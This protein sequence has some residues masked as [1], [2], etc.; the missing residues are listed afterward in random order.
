MIIKSMNKTKTIAA[1][2]TPVLL[3]IRL[4]S[5]FYLSHYFMEKWKLCDYFL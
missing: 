4:S 3:H 2:L 1:P 5:F